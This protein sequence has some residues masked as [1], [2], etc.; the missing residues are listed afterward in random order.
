MKSPSLQQM[1]G[2]LFITGFT[3]NTL[4]Q[5]DLIYQDI[6]K[7]YLGGVILFDRHLATKTA[8]N[9]ITGKTQL[10]RLTSQLQQVRSDKLLIAVDQ[11][12]GK[13]NRFREEFGF[14]QTPPAATLGAAIHTEATKKHGA[15]T[16]TTLRSCGVNLNLAPVVDLNLNGQNPIIGMVDRSF[17]KDVDRV[18]AHA[19]A[20]I[21]EHK[22]QG[23]GTCLKHFPG[24]GSSQSDSHLGFVDITESWEEYELE[25]YTNLLDKGLADAIMVGHLYNRRLDAKFPAT[26][27][28]KTIT[29]LLRTKMKFEGVVISD[30]LQMRAITNKYGLAQACIAA[31]NAGVDLLIIGNNLEYDPG[32]YSRLYNAVNRAVDNGTISENTIR[33]AYGRVRKL[34][35]TLK[36]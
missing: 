12:G 10:R 30:D 27:S 16:A 5:S 28:K 21:A 8:T 19:W 17:S 25:P 35:G 3:G 31:I 9:N 4:S 24:H 32:N 18:T 15:Q 26:L 36:N 11:E 2:Q 7:R 1:I 23:I 14:P 22:R 13:V 34:K 20:W 6:Q 33:S 29:G